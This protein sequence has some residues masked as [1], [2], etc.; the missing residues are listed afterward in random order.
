MS[1]GRNDSPA[2]DVRPIGGRAS[3]SELTDESEHHDNKDFEKRI[4]DA[5]GILGPFNKL[6]ESTW[7]SSSLPFGYQNCTNV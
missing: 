6:D 2:G 7:T 3:V 5:I 1:P 4:H